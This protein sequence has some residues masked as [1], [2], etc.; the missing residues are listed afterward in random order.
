MAE[1]FLDQKWFLAYQ[2]FAI[3]VWV[4][5]PCNKGISEQIAAQGGA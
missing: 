1:K 5:F 4:V 3:L 2:A